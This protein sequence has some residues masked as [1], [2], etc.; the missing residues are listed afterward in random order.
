MKRIFGRDKPKATKVTNVREIVGATA[1]LDVRESILPVISLFIHTYCV[2]QQN[3][4]YPHIYHQNRT[5]REAVPQRSMGR[6]STDGWEVMAG[7]K[8]DA[9]HNSQPKQ[10]QYRE[11]DQI[12][13]P[14]PP[15]LLDSRSSSLAS[16]PPG[17]SPPIPSPHAPRSGSPLSNSNATPTQGR[18]PA[19]RER[20]DKLR[21]KLTQSTTSGAPALGILKALDPF[22][23]SDAPPPP[24]KESKIHKQ[25]HGHHSDEAPGDER[26]DRKNFW[27][28]DREKDRERDRAKERNED[29]PAELTRMIGAYDGFPG[30]TG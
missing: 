28:K 4:Q 25:D 1:V 9:S 8:E 20:D 24:E 27:G 14:R 6:S 10:P 16:L 23:T 18:G 22:A 3:P 17:A 5:P 13:N 7:Y 11:R 26:K 30:V 29:G 15:A 19:P 21:K 2:T 12:P